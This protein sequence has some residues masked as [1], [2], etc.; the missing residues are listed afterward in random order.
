MIS[1]K[2]FSVIIPTHNRSEIVIDSIES[3]LKQTYKYYE[4]IVIDDASTD[5]TVNKL[6]KL[7][8]KNT[9]ISIISH[10]QNMGVS[11]SRNIGIQ[12]A[13]YDWICFLDSDDLWDDSK[14]YKYNQAINIH[15]PDYIHSNEIWM[16]NNKIVK[17]PKNFA[18]YGDDIT[19]RCIKQCLFSTSTLCISK[20]I[21]LEYKMYD[22]SL[23]V[24]E[25][26][27]LFLKLILDNKTSYFIEEALT[28]KRA[29]I[30]KQLSFSNYNLEIYRFISLVKISKT[31]SSNHHYYK[32]VQAELVRKQLIVEKG[33]IKYNNTD[34]IQLIESL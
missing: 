32:D 4:I 9:S 14:L 26:Y 1:N 33:A 19:K 8:S 13:Q 31:L 17:Q 24:C 30:C 25:D 6:T 18:K 15:N 28:I 27:N 22:E 7:Y 20:K 10:K 16:R 21:L 34:L 11:Y 12:Q 5:N 29:G 2:Y 23:P 3:I